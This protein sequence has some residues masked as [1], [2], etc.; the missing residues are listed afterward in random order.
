MFF[1]ALQESANLFAQLLN[2]VGAPSSDTW[3]AR[4][5][6]FSPGTKAMLCRL[7]EQPRNRKRHC[8]ACFHE[9]SSTW[10]EKPCCHK[11]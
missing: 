4:G 2:L 5:F 1:I 7:L 8:Q 11:C 6:R 9:Q 10:Q 3:E